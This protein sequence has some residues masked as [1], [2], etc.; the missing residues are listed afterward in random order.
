MDKIDIHCHILPRLDDGS[1]SA[2][3]SLQMLRMSIEQDFITVIATPHYSAQFRGASAPVIQAWCRKLENWIHK[4]W[5]EEF[6]IYP[7][8]EILYFQ[9]MVDK[10]KTGELLTMAGSNYV[11]IE[12]LPDV[13]YSMVFGAV[14]ELVMEGYWPILAHVERYGCMRQKGRTEEITE[15][16]GY[17]QMNYRRIGGKWHDETTRWC[18]AM[19]KE[20]KIHFL[21]TDMHN[22]EERRPETREEEKWM[23]KHLSKRYLKNILYNN[24]RDILT[25]TRI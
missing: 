19:L 14:R 7:G 23:N 16:G 18:R 12:F 3:M 22:T 20:E 10:L 5:T 9:D 24:A 17:L 15:A 21:G 4:N 13:P 11:L 25:N 6:K 8:Q 2:K 1:D